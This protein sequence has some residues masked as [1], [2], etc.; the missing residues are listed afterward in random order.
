M[1]TGDREYIKGAQLSTLL[2]RSISPYNNEPLS[3]TQESG[4]ACLWMKNINTIST[5]NKEDRE[6]D[7]VKEKKGKTRQQSDRAW[8]TKQGRDY[9]NIS[10]LYSTT[11]HSLIRFPH[12]RG[13]VYSI[14]MQSASAAF[15]TN[16]VSRQV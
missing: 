16:A 14:I 10:F 4:Q 1:K 6:T 8:N 7:T 13:D 3:K 12:Q 11:T 2:W 5:E 9:C 15:E